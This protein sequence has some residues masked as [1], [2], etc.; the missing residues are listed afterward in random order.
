MKRITLISIVM[1][2][3]IT[4]HSQD[5]TGLWYA[6]SNVKTARLRLALDIKPSDIEGKYDIKLQSTDQSKEWFQVDSYQLVD[7]QLSFSVSRLSLSAQCTFQSDTLLKGTLRQHGAN[8]PLIFTRTSIVYNRPQ[9]PK[10]PFPYISKDITFRNNEDQINLAGTLTLP[11][12]KKPSKAVILLSG[13]GPQSRDSEVFEHKTFAIIADYLARQ[14]IATL[15]FDKRGVAESEGDFSTASIPE[16]ASDAEAAIEYLKGRPEIISNQIGVIG[17]SEGAAVAFTIAAQDMVNFVITLAGGGINGQELLL[18][19]RAA[20]LK[21]SGADSAFIQNYN[22]YMRDAQQIALQTANK[23]TCQTQLADLFRGSE[24]AGSEQAIA[25]QLHNP[26]MLG[27]LKYDPA[28]DYPDI[29]VPV[30][31]LNGD[32]D[33]QV[34]VENLKYIEQG[35]L[36]NGNDRV[37]TKVF[38]GLNHMFQ[39][40][41]TGLPDEYA[42]IEESFNEEVLKMIASWIEKL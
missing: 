15:R 10:A 41:T 3:T 6:Q 19:Q 36:E 34:P 40:A 9:T 38:P 22:K 13:S 25:A 42:I 39:T 37:V 35:L 29:T 17:H 5:F 4:A 28:W 1:L 23:E 2:L 11:K 20:L 12:T 7:D 31:A 14:G 33:R 16:F 21:A 18:M 27:M 24:L 26:T 32:K 8:F 30:L